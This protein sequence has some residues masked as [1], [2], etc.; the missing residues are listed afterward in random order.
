MGRHALP[1]FI[2]GFE[3]RLG[4]IDGDPA[5]WIVFQT[6]PGP[7]SWG[8]EAA[9]HV[10]AMNSLQDGIMPDLLE[11]FEDRFPYFR[12]EASGTRKVSAV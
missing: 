6:L 7:K 2:T 1:D 10:S 9:R 8:P 5:M 3:V 11:A 12:Y 4:D